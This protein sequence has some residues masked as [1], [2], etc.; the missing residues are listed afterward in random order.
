MSYRRKALLVTTLAT[1]L[2]LGSA[3]PGGAAGSWTVSG[4][5]FGHGGGMSQWGAYGYAKHGKGYKQIL[6]H[7][8]RGA[9]VGKTGSSKIRVLL[10]AGAANVRFSGAKSGCGHNLDPAKTYRAARSGSAVVLQRSSG[11]RIASCGSKLRAKGAG[12]L[13][14]S[15]K[16]TYRGDL[17]ATPAAGSG[18]NA[19]NAVPLESYVRGVIANEV[20]SSWPVAALQAQAV[21]AR[22]YVLATRHGGISDVYDDTRS[23]VYRGRGSETART[24]QAAK[25]TAA[26]VVRSGGGVAAT[27]FYSSSGGETE[28]IEFAMPGATPRSYL[29]AVKD[30]YDGAAPLHSWKRTFSD[31]RMQAALGNLV[32]GRLKA[33]EVTKTGRSPRIV[34]A[35]L[36]GSSGNSSVS[37]PTLRTRLGLP[38]TW[39]RFSGG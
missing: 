12:K 33:V 24:N 27:F 19:V 14:V 23:Q 26:Q 8:Y 30:P 36:V 20:P 11:A 21:A 2:A 22:S 15:G 13:K 31:A 17:E 37:G 25:A 29:V 32:P 4:H 18:L 3:A 6:L 7:Y 28:N 39:A 1:A 34:T 16:G 5:G 35:R 10:L 9:T 38:S